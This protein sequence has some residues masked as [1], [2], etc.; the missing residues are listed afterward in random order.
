MEKHIFVIIAIC[1]VYFILGGLATTNILRLTAGN[2]LPVRSSKCFCDYC[3]TKITPFLQLPVISYIICKG[4]CRNCGG[5]IPV[6]PLLLEI[7]IFIG[8]SLISFISDFSALGIFFSFL[9]Y[10][11]VRL[12]FIIIKGKREYNFCREYIIAVLSMFK[13]LIS[14]EFFA[15]FIK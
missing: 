14:V 9:Y 2:K 13:Y 6:Y 7:A 12:G 3:G 1:T 10:E 5:K 11:T 4:K 15:F 8:M